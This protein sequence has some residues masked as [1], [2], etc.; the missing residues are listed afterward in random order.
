MTTTGIDHWLHSGR[1]Y[2]SL[3]W[4]TAH[5]LG[6]LA[7]PPVRTVFERQIYFTGIEALWA[8][9]VMGLLAGGIVVTQ[10]TFVAGNSE[11]IGRTLTLVIVRELGPLLA[12]VL[13]ICRSNVAIATELGLMQL[14]GGTAALAGMRIPPFDYLVVPR[15]A[16]VTLSAL[17][18]TV[19]FDAV[20]VAGGIGV[21]AL[22]QNV[23]FMTLGSRFVDAVALTYIAVTAGKSLCFGLAVSAIAC[24]HGL[25]QTSTANDIPVA[26]MRAVV[27]G[28][29]AVLVI[30]AVFD[31]MLFGL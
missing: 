10:T 15:V 11:L 7:I 21:S 4:Q 28:L 25:E 22:F 6:A 16:A 30:D 20:A 29:L 19:Y 14:R 23:S 26:T 31:W 9:A 27:R 2:V 17:A 5:R 1:G 8:T 24:H 12:A 13:I 3:L 18:L